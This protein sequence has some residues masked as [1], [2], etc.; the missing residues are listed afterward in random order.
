MKDIY[1]INTEV[2]WFEEY[3]TLFQGLENMRGKYKIEIKENVQP[4]GNLAP[5]TVHFLLKSQ[6][7]EALNDMQKKGVIVP[8]DHSTDWC[9]PMVVCTKKNSDARIYVKAE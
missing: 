6:V 9:A 3:P 7:K 8:I 2:N 4:Y 5:R 1:A